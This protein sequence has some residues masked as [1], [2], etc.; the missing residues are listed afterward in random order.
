MTELQ[1]TQNVSRRLTAEEIRELGG[2]R[3]AIRVLQNHKV[4]CHHSVDPP[5]VSSVIVSRGLKICRR[6]RT[7]RDSANKRKRLR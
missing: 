7:A 2:L 5:A 3:N 6:H 1:E 4:I